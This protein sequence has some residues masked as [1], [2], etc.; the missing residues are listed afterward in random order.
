MITTTSMGVLNIP[1][2]LPSE[3]S[4]TY[5]LLYFRIQKTIKHWYW[6]PLKT[7][8][9]YTNRVVIQS[10]SSFTWVL[11]SSARIMAKMYLPIPSVGPAIT[12]KYVIPS[13]GIKTSKALV[14]FRYC[15]VSTLL[16]DRS[17]IM[18]TLKTHF[19]IK[20]TFQFFVHS[21]NDYGINKFVLLTHIIRRRK[22][23]FITR[24][25]DTGPW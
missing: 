4:L 6:E 12:T 2:I 7:I 24:H 23:E 20:K 9:M 15:L 14:A 13:N 8:K 22:I 1:F 16:F 19:L 18:S 5:S 10:D 17:L 21:G 11:I 25:S 3:K